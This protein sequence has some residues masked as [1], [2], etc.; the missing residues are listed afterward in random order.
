M[1]WDPSGTRLGPVW[2]PSGTRLVPV[3][4]P[5]GTRL[6]PV[7]DPSAIFACNPSSSLKSRKDIKLM[8]LVARGPRNTQMYIPSMSINVSWS[9]EKYA[10]KIDEKRGP[11][12]DPSG[13]R[14]GP[15]WGPSGTRLGP[16]WD[17]S[18]S[19]L[20]PV[21]DPSGTRLVVSWDPSGTRL[22]PVW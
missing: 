7:W 19:V 1:S 12:W 6:G 18:G 14:L 16:V 21:W 20:G 22:G 4:D 9:I 5:S 13:T 10:P 11:V 2:D 17:P 15:V 8:I 3:W